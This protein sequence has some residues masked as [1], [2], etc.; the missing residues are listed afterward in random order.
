MLAAAAT[1]RESIPAAIAMFKR[2]SAVSIQSALRPC[3]SEPSSR[4]S[5]AGAWPELDLLGEVLVLVVVLC[6]VNGVSGGV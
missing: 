5:F 4:A 1:L 3:P 2:A 6:L